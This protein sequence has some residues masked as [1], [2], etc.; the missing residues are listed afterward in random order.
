M[1]KNSINNHCIK[2]KFKYFEENSLNFD[3]VLV[4]FRTNNFLESYNGYIK[5]KLKG[6]KN[7]KLDKFFAFYKRR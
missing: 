3:L 6:K 1:E 5:F 2:E 7:Y 4:N